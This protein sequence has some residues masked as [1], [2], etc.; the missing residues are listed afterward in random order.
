MRQSRTVWLLPPFMYGRVASKNRF[1]FSD[2]K[3]QTHDPTVC[4]SPFPSFLDLYIEPPQMSLSLSKSCRSLSTISTA[5]FMV[6][7]GCGCANPDA[8]KTPADQA[9]ATASEMPAERTAAPY[10]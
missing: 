3:L 2:L 7:E 10:S 6:G 1:A 4:S 8:S 9:T 5:T